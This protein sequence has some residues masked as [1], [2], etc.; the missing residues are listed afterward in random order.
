MQAP[1]D[2]QLDRPPASIR[3]DARLDA[4]TRQKV[5]DLA[6]HF[7]QPRAAVLRYIMRWGLDRKAMAARDQGETRGPVRHLYLYVDA[8]LYEAMR[9]AAAAAG[10]HLAPW[11]RQMVRH[12]PITDFPGSWEEE[13]SARRSHDSHTYGVRFMLRLDTAS[14]TT[15]QRLAEHF[16]VPRAE[17]IRQLLAQATPK[18]F[19]AG[20]HLRASERDGKQTRLV[21]READQISEG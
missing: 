14:E 21:L 11:L 4:E 2:R 16:D 12:I 5:D 19:P 3:M 1:P 20:W 7:R 18:A 17:I 10:V 13:R 15:L 6:R 9:K 8:D